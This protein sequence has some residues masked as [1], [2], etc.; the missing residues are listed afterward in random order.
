M[1]DA[2]FGDGGTNAFG[3]RLNRANLQPHLAQILT[4]RTA[5]ARTNAA[6]IQ[7]VGRILAESSASKK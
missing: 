3:A 1:L 2:M 4:N 6:E 7:W 5:Y